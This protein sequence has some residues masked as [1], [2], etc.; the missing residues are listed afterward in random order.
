[1][2]NLLA[3]MQVFPTSFNPDQ[4]S[5]V[6]VIPESP[7]QGCDLKA[8]LSHRTSKRAMEY[9]RLPSPFSVDLY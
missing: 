3:F 6:Y 5:S 2:D 1:M 9:K 7:G 8:H 4:E